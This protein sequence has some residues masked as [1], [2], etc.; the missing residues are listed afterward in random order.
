ML[1]F[2]LRCNERCGVAKLTISVQMPN[3][4]FTPIVGESLGTNAPDVLAGLL[5][6]HA[7]SVNASGETTV[8]WLGAVQNG[9]LHGRNDTFV[10]R[11]EVRTEGGYFVVGNCSVAIQWHGEQISC[12]RRSPPGRV[13]RIL[14][15]GGTMTDGLRWQLSEAEAID[16]IARGQKFFVELPIGMRAEVFVARTKAGRKY[17]RTVGDAGKSNNLLSQSECP[18]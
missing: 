9:S 3:G 13:S 10:F 5:S 17:L 15:V 14:S 18:S 8:F 2:A 7:V 12:I 6:N 4:A 16:E 11:L 1:R